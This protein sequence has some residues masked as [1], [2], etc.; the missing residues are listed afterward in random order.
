MVDARSLPRGTV[1]YHGTGAPEKF[2][3]PTGPAF[4]SDSRTVAKYFSTWNGGE[5]PRVLR[6][7]VSSKIQ[8]LALIES[9]QDFD[10]LSEET[11]C[12]PGQDTESLVAMVC[13]AGFDGWIIPNNYPDGADIMLCFPERSLKFVEEE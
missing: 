11:G 10:N 3:I 9:Q 2:L 4:F 5:K 1:L 8:K 6:Y 12:E 13:G 7:K